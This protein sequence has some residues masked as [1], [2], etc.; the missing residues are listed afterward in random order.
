MIGWVNWSGLATALSE[1][2][3]GAGPSAPRLLQARPVDS[4]ILGHYFRRHDRGCGSISLVFAEKR[5]GT[6]FDRCFWHIFQP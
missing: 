4:G 6:I 5:I 1:L 2:D 3:F